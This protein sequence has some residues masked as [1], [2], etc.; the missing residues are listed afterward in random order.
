MTR[1]VFDN[2]LPPNIALDAGSEA[3]QQALHRLALKDLIAIKESKVVDGELVKVISSES[4][5]PLE[6]GKLSYLKTVLPQE[7]NNGFNTCSLFAGAGGSALGLERVGYNVKACYELDKNAYATLL[8]N[9]PQWNPTLADISITDFT[10]LNGTIDV[11]EGGFPC[12]PFSYAGSRAGFADTRG[13]LFHHY[14]RAVHEIEPKAFIAE[15][16]PGLLTNDKGR[17][18]KTI[19]GNLEIETPGGHKYTIHHKVLKSH[20]LGIPQKRDR[21]IIVGIRNDQ[22]IP[23]SYEFPN[24]LTH[25]IPLKAAL[26]GVP[27][28]AGVTYSPAK[29]DI[30]KQVPEGG[31]W[32]DLPD[33]LQNILTNGKGGIDGSYSG[34]AKRLSWNEPSLTILASPAQRRTE[35]CH[36][37]ET[38]PLTI[39]EAA[40]VQTFPDD[41]VFEGGVTTQYRQVGNAVPPR[42]AYLVG[43]S[44][45]RHLK[46]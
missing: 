33:E 27:E 25:T 40:R 32:R 1:Y 19:K 10:H 46:S 4:Y 24:Y 34:T 13:T 30:M 3:R 43:K 44:I 29:Y 11:L 37:T 22:N 45:L 35:R 39:R 2:V 31:N 41:W 23:F 17:T 8:A 14:L 7:E 12:Q 20:W 36:P 28:S 26:D 15:N 18:W 38:R 6:S 42:L 21:L 9:R 16:V 5:I